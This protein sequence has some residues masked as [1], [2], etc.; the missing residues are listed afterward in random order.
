M[1]Q[2][3]EAGP[4]VAHLLPLAGSARDLFLDA[5]WILFFTP[6]RP[7]PGLGLEILQALYDLAPS[8]ATLLS[9]LL[10]GLSVEA[11]AAASGISVNT[12][13]SYLK[14]IFAKTNVRRQTKLM[15]LLGTSFETG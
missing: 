3:G 5:R 4:M 13:R 6:V 10:D 14:S 12:A 8:E 9:A 15:R 11:A 1:P 7:R 2:A